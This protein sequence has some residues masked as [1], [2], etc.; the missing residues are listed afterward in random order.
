MKKRLSNLLALL[1]FACFA[2]VGLVPAGATSFQSFSTASELFNA[3]NLVVVGTVINYEETHL[4]SPS[5]TLFPHTVSSIQIAEV[6][7]GNAQ[8]GDIIQERRP[9]HRV[10][11][12]NEEGYVGVAAWPDIW[13][14]VGQAYLLFLYMFE[15]DPLAVKLNPGQSS[16]FID[17]AGGITAR[18]GNNI[19]IASLDTLRALANVPS[20]TITVPA[21][22]T[23]PTQNILTTTNLF[24]GTGSNSTPPPQTGVDF[25]TS[26]VVAIV[27]LGLCGGYI[28]LRYFKNKDEL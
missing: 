1:L 12:P 20:P 24:L 18:P 15:A 26:V 17:E 8:I 10:P 14:E 3:A 27:I 28:G 6:I 22:T 21:T 19:A 11:T 23:T 5:D 4:A 2:F 13:L 7:K 25:N 16:Y 9:N